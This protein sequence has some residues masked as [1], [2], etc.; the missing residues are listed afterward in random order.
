MLPNMEVGDSEYKSI[1]I[2]NGHGQGQT[3]PS[4]HSTKGPEDTDIQSK[5]LES[6]EDPVPC[7]RGLVPYLHWEYEEEVETL[8]RTLDE[9]RDRK[10]AWAGISQAQ[11]T[12]NNSVTR[13]QRLLEEY[14]HED[15][16]LHI[17]R[18]LDQY[19]Y[20][21]SSNLSNRDNDQTSLRHHKESTTKNRTRPRLTMVDQLWMWVLPKCESSPPTIITAFPQSSNTEKDAGWQ[22]T[23]LKNIIIRCGYLSVRSCYGVAEIIA[24][25]CSRHYLGSENNRKEETRFLRIY[26][27][28][29]GRIMD[30]DAERFR[31]FQDNVNKS[32]GEEVLKELVATKAI[33]DDIEDLRQIKDIQDELNI[34]NSLFHVQKEVFQTMRQTIQEEKRRNRPP[35]ARGKQSNQYIAIFSPEAVIER[36]INEVKRL[37]S[38]AEKAADAVERLLALK[39]K[40]ADLILTTKIYNINDATDRQGKTIMTFTTVTIIFLPLSFLASF[41][42]LDIKQFPR[43]G[44]KLSLAWVLEITSVPE[45]VSGA[46]MLQSFSTLASIWRSLKLMGGRNRR[47]GHEEEGEDS[48]PATDEG[49]RMT[50]KLGDPPSLEAEPKYGGFTRF[51]IELEVCIA[52]LRSINTRTILL[53]L[54]FVSDDGTANEYLQFVQ[55]LANPFYLNH[56][57]SLK[58]LNDPAFIAYLAYLQYWSRPPYIKYLNYPGPT[59]KHL[60]LLQEERFRQD[61]ISPELVQALA[62]EG[63]KASV[64]WHKEE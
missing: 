55:S 38:L 61:I 64:E 16:P 11:Q 17:R 48:T 29:I 3:T 30:R 21:S 63:V 24:A 28:S 47:L 53:S 36:N 44:D 25:E 33:R 5:K 12:P 46:R 52:I 49:E 58:L 40:Q 32:G 10:K 57:A 35:T 31:R 14:V 1:L 51:E 8:K 50:A 7:Q 59:L 15:H 26:E 2:D 62:A 37:E 43:D 42:A 60:E 45:L 20:P 41:L 56:L 19:Y 34:M 4:N 13:D 27:T 6:E 39:Q 22:T 54:S 23:L 18:T 9:I